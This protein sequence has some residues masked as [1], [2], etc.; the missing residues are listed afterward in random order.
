MFVHDRLGDLS[1]PFAVLGCSWSYANIRVSL[2]T[3]SRQCQL[4]TIV[5]GSFDDPPM[6]GD[7]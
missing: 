1:V 7:C 2:A 6:S 4:S 3:R 5:Q